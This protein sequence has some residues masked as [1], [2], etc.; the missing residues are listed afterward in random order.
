MTC[1]VHGCWEREPQAGGK[2]MPTKRL[3]LFT[4]LLVT[5]IAGCTTGSN[6][7]HFVDDMPAGAALRTP[8]EHRQM[9]AFSESVRLIHGELTA[10]YDLARHFQRMGSHVIAIE[11]LTE[12]L[13][14]NPRYVQAHN[15]MGYSLDCIGDYSNARQHYKAAIALNPELDYAYNNLG[16]SYILAGDYRSAIVALEKAV[17]MNESNQK[18]IKNLGYAYFMDGKPAMA[19]NAFGRL[20]DPHVVERIRKQLGLVSPTNQVVDAGRT[21]NL[22]SPGG[23]TETRKNERSEQSGKTYVNAPVVDDLTYLPL[24]PYTPEADDLTYLPP[25]SETDPTSR[26]R[27]ASLDVIIDP[28]D[29]LVA[30][31]ADEPEGGHTAVIEVS[32]GNGVRRMAAM[33]GDFLKRNGMHVTRLTNADHFG[34]ARTVIYYREGYYDE[35]WQV[36]RLLPGLPDQGHLVAARLDREPVRVLIGQD[37]VAFHAAMVRDVDVEITNGNGVDGMA[38]R[39]GRRLRREGFRVGRLTNANHFDYQKTVLFYGKGKAD[40]AML[41]ADVLP[42]GGR[43]RMVELDQTGMHVQV[44]MGADMVF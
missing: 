42:G 28:M 40:Q 15:A 36:Q 29:F 21:Q 12:I 9:E 24:L 10:K 2:M 33:V 6:G 23:Q 27:D 7:G 16:Y 31:G 41:I 18:Y 32:N 25:I 5:L 1:G 34:H 8:I 30:D 43:V 20:D 13:S 3:Y 26:V 38:G 14:A 22:P 11:A 19:E 35:A 37:L 4:V 39:L 17:T 44:L